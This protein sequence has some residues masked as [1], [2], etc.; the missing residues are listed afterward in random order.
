MG[1]LRPLCF[2]TEQFLKLPPKKL[3]AAKIFAHHAAM[4]KAQNEVPEIGNRMSD[5]T[6]YAGISPTTGEHMYASAVDTSGSMTFEEAEEFIARHKSDFLL[7]DKAELQVLFDN[8][9]KGALKDTFNET[10]SSP[11]GFYW[12]STRCPGAYAY[13]IKFDDGS[14]GKIDKYLRSS[15][16]YIRYSSTPDSR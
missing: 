5:G 9:D 4:E 2:M 7:P 14:L 3:V 13:G 11:A 8:K 10:G 15:V 16:R 12:S 1:A 6:I